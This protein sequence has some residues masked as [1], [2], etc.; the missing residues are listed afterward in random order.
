MKTIILAG[1]MGTRLR[2]LTLSVPKPLIPIQG[3]TLTE[4]VIDIFKNIGISDFSL[5][6]SYHAEKLRE[7][8]DNGRQFGVDIEYIIEEEPLGTAG[9]LIILNREKRALNETFFMVNG[10]NLFNINL[11]EMLSIHRKNRATATIGLTAVKDVGAYGVAAVEKL[12]N[13]MRIKNFVE[14]P[15]PREAPSNFINSGYYILEPD[16]FEIVKGK[17]KAMMEQDVFPQ[18]AKQGKLF[19]FYDD[20]EW[21]DTG[22][23]D[24]YERVQRS[25]KRREPK[26]RD[27]QIKVKPW[28]REIW[29]AHTDLYAGKILEITKGHRLS[30]Q[31]H[32]YKT[33]TLYLLSGKAKITFGKSQDELSERIFN[34]GDKIDINPYTVHRVEA[35]ENTQIFEV[36]TPHL[37]DV[38]KLEDDYG[39]T[40]KGVNE[41]IDRK[42]WLKLQK[43]P[44]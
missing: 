8:F 11:E 5:S 26:G 4:H 19:G 14:K 38:V 36:S 33:E 41:E 34:P 2:P 1:G 32:E 6:I 24:R 18:L 9:P 44:T 21:F 13:G 39:R 43:K 12:E 15:G 7:Y 29:F 16:V 3:K 20:S 35:L 28:G 25:W 17:D 37:T 22:T 30:L 40:G 23:P 31:Y 27:V 10:D 42:L